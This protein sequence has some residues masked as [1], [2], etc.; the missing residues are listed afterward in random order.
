M[1]SLDDDTKKVLYIIAAIKAAFGVL[2]YLKRLTCF[3]IPY[4]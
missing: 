1:R 3:V 2:I 4:L